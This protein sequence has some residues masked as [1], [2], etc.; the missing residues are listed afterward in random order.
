MKI[1]KRV[2]SD[3]FYNYLIKLCTVSKKAIMYVLL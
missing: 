2:Y 1:L 3:N